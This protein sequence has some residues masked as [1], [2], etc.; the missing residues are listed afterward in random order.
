MIAGLILLFFFLL[1]CAF[2]FFPMR[3]GISYE[4]TNFSE[5]IFVH[6]SFFGILIRI[7]INNKKESGKKS[8]QK[9]KIAP[10]TAFTFTLFKKN[11][12]KFGEFFKISKD[13]LR[14]MLAFVRKHLSCSNVDFNI[15]FG[16]GDA[17]KTGIATGAVWASGTFLLKLIDALLGIKKIK[18]NVFPDFKE[19]KFEIYTKTILTMRPVY[20]IIIA[21][22]ISKTIKYIK[23]KIN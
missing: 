3:F 11:V 15:H 19:E 18:M 9:L 2:L 22:K 1:I 21:S 14:T 5:K 20:F 23:T 8:E 12:D 10:K 17:A 4:K 7:P 6:I 13:E 16:L